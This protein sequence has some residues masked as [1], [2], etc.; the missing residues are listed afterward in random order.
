M[1]DDEIESSLSNPE[2]IREWL[3][4]Q[5]LMDKN[6]N[7]WMPKIINH[8]AKGFDINII[9]KDKD[10]YLES[11]YILDKQYNKKPV[12]DTAIMDGSD[13]TCSMI[14]T[15]ITLKNH[16]DGVG[17]YAQEIAINLGLNNFANDLYLAG[18]LHDI[19]KVDPRFQKMLVGNDLVHS[20][21]LEE[22]LAKSISGVRQ[23]GKTYPKGM[24]HEV[25]SVAMLESNH[26]VLS[27]AC[28]KDLVL[29]LGVHFYP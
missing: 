12:V 7:Q 19:G 11:Y 8:L 14:C 16:L 22:P 24:R 20:A 5:K 23:T 9:N 28:D 18:C 10:E 26:D 15:D 4:K 6:K 21:M 2:R 1:P 27:S 3:G 17:R 25:S 13:E 29:H